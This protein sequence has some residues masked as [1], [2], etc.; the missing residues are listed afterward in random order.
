MF[1]KMPK[2]W[3][4]GEC[5]IIG[6]G[7]SIVEQF[8]IPDNVVEAVKSGEAPL[9]EYSPY[10]KALH[11]KHVIGIN[12]AFEIGN[13]VDICFF[14]DQS[15]Y[16]RFKGGLMRFPNLKINCSLDV[17]K[18]FPN[19]KRMRRLATSQTYGIAT[20]PDSLRWNSNSGGSAINLAYHTG[21]KRVYLLGYDMVKNG[22]GTHWHNSYGKK[23][24]TPYTTH[25][26]CFQHIARDAEKL[27][28]EIINVNPQSA[29]KQF[30]KKALSEIL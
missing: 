30:P 23:T 29:I 19:V 18:P 25:L 5:W 12:M 24:R 22:H 2:I 26:K 1:W 8:N 14:G 16:G 21:V 6:G 15:F 17:S 4:G 13:W 10:L 11:G 7:P 3:D 27:G 9:S 28:L 20:K